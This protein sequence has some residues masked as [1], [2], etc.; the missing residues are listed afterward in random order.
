MRE[1]AAFAFNLTWNGGI[2]GR[3]C[4]SKLLAQNVLKNAYWGRSS[5]I[6]PVFYLRSY[7]IISTTFGIKDL[8]LM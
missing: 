1:V 5:L 6:V 2:Y 7:S 8:K 3:R 4:K